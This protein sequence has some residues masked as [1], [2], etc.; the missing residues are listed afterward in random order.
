MFPILIYQMK[1]LLGIQSFFERLI[2]SLMTLLKV[3]L[4]SRQMQLP[5]AGNKELVI[6]GNG[7]SLQ[8]FLH[9]HKE[10]L[11]GKSTLAVNHFADTEAYSQVQPDYYVINV[12][13]FWT[14]DVDKDVLER[15]N[16]LLKNL[17]TKTQWDMKLLLGAGAKKSK[18]WTSITD[19]NPHISTYFF[20]TTPVEGFRSF[21]HFCY[22]RNC[23]M[24]RPHNVLIPS[25]M[26][27]INMLYKKIYI[28]GADHSWME[29]LFVAD[30]NTV[31]LTQRHFYDAQ[32]A[33][34]DVMKKTGKGQRKLHEI[35]HKFM[36][37]FKG[38]WDINAYAKSRGTK[39][40][41]ITPQSMIDAFKR[42]RI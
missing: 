35:L 2:Q 3:V 8:D 40:V 12:P 28:S 10:F 22:K 32:S 33:R 42:E 37:A 20:N 16:K 19:N 24:P 34:P 9:K 38:Y 4:M 30:D 11:S 17:V 21:R 29:D 15:R 1:L 18:L 26:L 39:I 5:K 14:D 36:L 23:G 27:G 25:L 13:E 31:Y 6:L 41:N 7:P